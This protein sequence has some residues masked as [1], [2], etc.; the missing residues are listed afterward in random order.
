MPDK[1]E[2]NSSK[3]NLEA[4]RLSATDAVIPKESYKTIPDI[5]HHQHK[6]DVEGLENVIGDAVKNSNMVREKVDM[7]EE[8]ADE[9]MLGAG[10][11]EQQN[12][13]KKEE[14]KFI[15][16]GDQVNGDAKIDIG[17]VDK[18]FTGLTKE[19]L[20]KFANDPF[21]V[22][23]R[24]FLFVCFWGLWAG[25]LIGAVLIIIYAPKCAAPEPLSWW[26]QGPLVK[27]DTPTPDDS[28]VSAIK[29][30]GV[31]GVIYE[32]PADETYNIGT[33]PAISDALKKLAGAFSAAGVNLIVDLTP[34]FVTREDPLFQRATNNPD[35]RSAFVW[36]EGN[37]VPNNWLSLVNGSAW[38]NEGGLIF[39]QQFGADR[40]DLQLK[41]PVA[42]TKLKGVLKEVVGLGAKGIRLANTKHFIINPELPDDIPSTI[43]NYVH[44][45]YDFW[46]HAH[47]TYQDGLGDLLYDLRTYVHNITS[48]E[49]FLASLDDIDRPELYVSSSG[50][51]SVDM[52]QLGKVPNL[53]ANSTAAKSV[54]REL[55]NV[56]VTVESGKHFW[57][58]WN[59]VKQEMLKHISLS[60]YNIFLQLL[61]GVPVFNVDA[62]KAKPEDYATDAFHKIRSSPSFM[63]GSFDLYRDVN[64]TV[65]GYSRSKSGNP[66]FFVVLNPTEQFVDANFTNVA[67]IADEL[68]VHTISANYNVTNVSVKAKV[69]SSSIPVS[70]YSAMILTYVPKG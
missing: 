21:W 33:D 62:P 41:D 4:Q 20:L 11:E 69:T 23:L 58:Q 67:G 10:E 7:S 44:T 29:A 60:E 64:S 18:A 47:T 9:K 27:I 68:T 49:G 39:L 42:L 55:R 32:V 6:V 17:A 57:M 37:Q 48:G 38:T 16:G 34:N 53:V 14:V 45:Q 19:E 56:W 3:L 12:L 52:I 30:L 66:G 61:P 5:D 22:R 35:A 13:A 70:G 63:H 65:I 46:A 31:K 24:W 2:R 54:Y 1:V 59:Y 25:M 28:V 15:S 50:L 8:G 26:K 51:P 40:F 43:P 36:R